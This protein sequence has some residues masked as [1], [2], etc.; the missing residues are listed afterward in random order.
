MNAMEQL[1]EF[2]S[3]LKDAKIQYMLDCQREAIMVTTV[4]PLAY[5]E[6]EFFADGQ[7]DVQ[8]FQAT[9]VESMSL[10]QITA[11]IMKQMRDE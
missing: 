9:P 10:D 2:I 3:Q 8:C 4:T 11:V 5:Y 7:I 6:V 1:L